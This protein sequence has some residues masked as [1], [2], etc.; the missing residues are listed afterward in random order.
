MQVRDVLFVDDLVDALPARAGRRSARSAGQA[1]NIGG[2]P[3]NTVS[4]LELLELIGALHGERPEVQLRAPGGRATSAT[5]CPTRGK[6]DAATGWRPRVGVARGRA[7]AL[8]SGCAEARGPGAAVARA[9]RERWRHEIRPGQS[10]LELRGQHLLRLPRAAPAARVRLLA[11]AARSATGTTA[12]IVDAQLEAC[13]EPAMRRAGRARSARHH[14]GDDRAELPV[15]ALRAARAARAA[16]DD[17]PRCA[18]VGGHDGR[19]GPARL[20]HARARRCASWAR[21]SR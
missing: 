10:A 11:G 7:A 4:L 6:F 3:G 17:R 13:D 18:S 2:G 9:A 19:R 8:P 12:Q 21:T 16:G 1:F 14:G 20:D 5:T 15:L